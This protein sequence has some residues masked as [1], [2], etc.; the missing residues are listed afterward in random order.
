MRE[1]FPPAE[2][3]YKFLDLKI[4]HVVQS[5]ANNSLCD[6][7]WS[8]WGNLELSLVFD[9]F[10]IWGTIRD[11]RLICTYSA[12]GLESAMSPRSPGSFPWGP[13]SMHF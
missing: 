11:S 12:P 3:Y 5:V 9:H 8:Q 4:F 7:D 2:T 6:A 13:R 10:L 1:F